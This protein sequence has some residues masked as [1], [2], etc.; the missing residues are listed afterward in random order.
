[1]PPRK[2]IEASWECFWMIFHGQ[3]RL[4]TFRKIVKLGFTCRQ[5]A[6]LIQDCEREG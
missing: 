4:E 1:M 6:E 3:T 5:A 2:H